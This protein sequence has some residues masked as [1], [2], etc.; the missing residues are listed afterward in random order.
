MGD[1]M[2]SS[3]ITLL[4]LL[5][6]LTGC[7]SSSNTTT[8]RSQNHKLKGIWDGDADESMAQNSFDDEFMS[9]EEQ[10]LHMRFADAAIPQPNEIPGTPGSGIPSLDQ[11][12]RALAGLAEIFQNIHFNTDE[13]VVRTR[14]DTQIIDRV[15]NYLK[16]HPN[17]YVA[18]G[19]HCDER[20]SESYNLAL[21][22][23]RSNYVRTLLVQR[24]VDSNKIHSISYGKEQPEALGHTPEAWAINRRVE[25]RI[26]EK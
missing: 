11:F 2:K 18:L 16:S 8:V 12:K 24:G 10:D 20:G 23:K 5:A 22:T 4:L 3:V 6:M 14:E 25:F 1:K 26:F 19:G 9:L 13:Y 7:G 21:G 17:T 15:A